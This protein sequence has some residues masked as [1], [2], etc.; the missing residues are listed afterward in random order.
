M[1]RTFE[2]LALELEGDRFAIPA[3][4][5]SALFPEGRTVVWRVRRLDPVRGAS[6]VGSESRRLTRVP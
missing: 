2:D 4:A 1:V 3:E 5:W 6:L